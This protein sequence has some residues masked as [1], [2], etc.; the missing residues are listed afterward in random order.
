MYS[1]DDMSIEAARRALGEIV[2]RARLMDE[3]TV[4]TRQGKRAAIVVST[5]WYFRV[6]D[7]G[8]LSPDVVRD[9]LVIAADKA[10]TEE[11]ARRFRNALS[12]FD[13]ATETAI[14]KAHGDGTE[15]TGEDQRAPVGELTASLR[16]TD[17]K[18][19]GR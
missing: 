13:R 15:T 4:I 14:R 17:P 18:E 2:D 11:Y 5:D 3:P 8:T 6:W 10:P 19:N 9:A 1:M 16:I 12:L 7:V